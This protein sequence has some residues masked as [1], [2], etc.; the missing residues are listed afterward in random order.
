MLDRSF[1]FARIGRTP[2]VGPKQPDT[3][4]F[5]LFVNDHLIA[6][7]TERS[8]LETLGT[9]FKYNCSVIIC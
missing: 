9:P 7:S 8:E 5:K 4:V 3:P 2:F 6:S 1:S